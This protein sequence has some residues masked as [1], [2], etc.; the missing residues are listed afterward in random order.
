[1]AS[2]DPFT[3]GFRIVE[4]L[5][6]RFRDGWPDESSG[7]DDCASTPPSDVFQ[8]REGWS[9]E[10]E[11]PGVSHADVAVRLSGGSLVVEADRGFSHAGER[12]VHT[13]EGRYGRVR[14][15]FLLPLDAQPERALAELRNGVLRVF[16]PRRLGTATI[17]RALE[18]RDAERG[19]PVEI[20]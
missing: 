6:G 11:L 17:E 19:G 15:T 16:V 3:D 12:Q 14:R 7:D 8:D 4:R 5:G 20:G 10:V 13:L 2:R 9:V 18:V 1:M